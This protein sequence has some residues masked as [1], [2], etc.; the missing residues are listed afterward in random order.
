MEKR[1]AQSRQKFRSDHGL[2]QMAEAK[3]IVHQCAVITTRNLMD[4]P[5]KFMIDYMSSCNPGYRMTDL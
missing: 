5:M 2:T 1:I 4:K 3:Q